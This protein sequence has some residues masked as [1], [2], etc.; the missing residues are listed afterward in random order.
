MGSSYKKAIFEEHIHEGLVGWARKAKK[1]NK[2][3]V[4]KRSANGSSHVGPKEESPLVF[5]MAE[6]DEKE[7]A[8]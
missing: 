7:S 4:F 2:G 1:N 6:V 8:V 5:E 3:N